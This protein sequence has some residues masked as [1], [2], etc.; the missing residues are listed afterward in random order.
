MVREG[1]V[2]PE[3]GEPDQVPDKLHRAVAVIAEQLNIPENYYP[4]HGWTIAVFILWFQP[5]FFVPPCT[6]MYPGVLDRIDL[7][8]DH[9]LQME[10]VWR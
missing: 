2:Y 6:H 10:A 5:S 8:P 3:R 4:N 1:C 9:C 7:M